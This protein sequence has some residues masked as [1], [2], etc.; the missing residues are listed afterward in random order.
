MRDFIHRYLGRCNGRP[1]LQPAGR[2]LLRTN[3]E[4]ARRGLHE[5]AQSFVLSC[6]AGIRVP[7]TRHR[8]ATNR[9]FGRTWTSCP[10]LIAT[11]SV[12]TFIA[13][14]WAMRGLAPTRPR[15]AG[16]AMGLAS[17]GIGAVVYSLHCPEMGAPFL[18]SWYLVGLLIPTADGYAPRAAA[19]ALVIRSPIIS[20]KAPI[21]D[22]AVAS[23]AKR[24]SRCRKSVS[25]VRRRDIRCP[26]LGVS[27]RR[28]VSRAATGLENASLLRRLP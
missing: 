11:L 21:L 27:L 15:L 9:L 23:L 7:V 4:K 16:A 17:G 26:G 18:G 28:P 25:C 8:D 20:S 5:Q 12:P 2:G 3:S 24:R 19:I 22:C 10:L 13:M 14:S 6:P 1:R